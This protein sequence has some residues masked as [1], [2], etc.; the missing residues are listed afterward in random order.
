M[1]DRLFG[2]HKAYHRRLPVDSS[3]SS[4]ERC[5]KAARKTV[6]NLRVDKQ[7]RGWLTSGIRQDKLRPDIKSVSTSRRYDPEGLD[8]LGEKETKLVIGAL[9]EK[10]Q[11]GSRLIMLSEI[12]SPDL[13]SESDDD[14]KRNYSDVDSDRLQRY[15]C[16]TKRNMQQ[17]FLKRVTIIVDKDGKQ[18]PC[19]SSSRVFESDKRRNE[20]VNTPLMHAEAGTTKEENIPGISR[21]KEIELV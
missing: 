10:E 9:D 5:K 1:C 7:L 20:T 11:K 8:S 19:A 15:G 12:I 21:D 6:Q 4:A 13:L 2:L 14:D 3:K 18:N 16:C 17:I